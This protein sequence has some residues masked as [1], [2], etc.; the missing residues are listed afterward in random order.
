MCE[1]PTAYDRHDAQTK[2]DNANIAERMLAFRL[3]S[4]SGSS[5]A[6]IRARRP[7]LARNS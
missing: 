2:S 5:I 3:M 1:W 7:Y 4:G 6:L